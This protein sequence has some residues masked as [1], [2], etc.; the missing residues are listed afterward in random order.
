MREGRDKGGRKEEIEKGGRGGGEEKSE[1][2]FYSFL[3]TGH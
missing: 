1:R 2:D 3:S